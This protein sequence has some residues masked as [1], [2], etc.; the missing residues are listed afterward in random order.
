MRAAPLRASARPPRVASSP[1]S[2]RTPDWSGSLLKIRMPRSASFHPRVAELQQTCPAVRPATTATTT[3]TRPKL[4]H[5]V[6]SIRVCDLPAGNRPG[7]GFAPNLKSPRLSNRLRIAEHQPAHREAWRSTTT[8]NRSPEGGRPQ[9]DVGLA[10]AQ[11]APARCSAR[12]TVLRSLSISPA[13]APLAGNQTC[14]TDPRAPDPLFDMHE[15]KHVSSRRPTQR[16]LTVGTGGPVITRDPATL[17]I[18]SLNE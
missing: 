7:L 9:T 10:C 6:A 13:A 15:A 8:T 18:Y 14:L 17:I 2:S 1:P 3:R 12:R 16:D 4:R 5:V 11:C